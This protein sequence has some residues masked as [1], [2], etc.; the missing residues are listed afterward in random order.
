[1]NEYISKEAIL[2]ELDST[3][4]RCKEE[5][6]CNVDVSDVCSA[7]SRFI[8][9]MQAVDVHPVK[10]GRWIYSDIPV[11]FNPHG[12]YLCSMCNYEVDYRDYNYCPNC[13]ARM[14]LKV[15]ENDTL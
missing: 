1:M 8:E 11:F 10:H 13:G 6:I 15:I 4:N 5:P 7:I 2:K 3:I 9:N 14:D 12:R